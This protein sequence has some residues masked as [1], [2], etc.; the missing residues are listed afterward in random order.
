M[1]FKL[2][3][4]LALFILLGLLLGCTGWH[5]RGQYSLPSSLTT[6]QLHS[7]TPNSPLWQQ[8]KLQLER[9]NIAIAQDSF[10]Q[11][12][13]GKENT[14]LKTETLNSSGQIIEQKLSYQIEVT[15]KISEHKISPVK[16]FR[17]TEIVPYSAEQIL[18]TNTVVEQALQ[19]LRSR[20]AAEIL[21]TFSKLVKSVV[22]HS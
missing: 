15:F 21:T 2:L 16:T 20:A 11:I 12:L 17:L 9:Q 8:L 10:F 7:T 18:G 6:L 5:L 3:S 4:R 22:S 13:L 1:N 14:Q 19:Q